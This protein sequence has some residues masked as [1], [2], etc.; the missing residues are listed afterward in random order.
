[1]GADGVVDFFPMAQFAIEF[2]HFQRAGGDLI[3]L[4]GVGAVGAFNGAVEFGRTWRQDE[5][6]EAA[7]L[8]GLFELGGKLRAAIDLD[9]ANGKGHAVLQG[10]E[11]LRGGLGGGT[12]MSLN[13]VPSGNHIARGELFEDHT[14][15]GTDVQA[16][17]FDQVAWLRSRRRL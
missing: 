9:G 7:L 10:V 8:A 14:G 3:E 11:K 1:M 12:G 15:D 2:F 5:E 16:I 6:M 4:L 17:D 13:H